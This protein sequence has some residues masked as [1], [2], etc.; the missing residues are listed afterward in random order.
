MA[1][2][3][4]LGEQVPYCAGGI[5]PEGAIWLLAC[6]KLLMET[7]IWEGNFRALVSVS[8]DTSGSLI[9]IWCYAFFVERGWHL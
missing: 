2:L 1:R 9:E 6:G 8:D 5:L 4:S 7:A 3:G